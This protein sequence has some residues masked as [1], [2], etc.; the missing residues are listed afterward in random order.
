MQSH[1]Q[2]VKAME[3][4]REANHP[5]PDSVPDYSDD[6]RRELVLEWLESQ[7]DDR[8]HLSEMLT[9]FAIDPDFQRHIVYAALGESGIESDAWCMGYLCR[10]VTDKYFEDAAE[11]KE[12]QDSDPHGW[13]DDA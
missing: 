10:V 12:S 13:G 8:N 5:A 6:Q 1:L 7:K 9:Q 11:W 3:A 2:A 4:Q